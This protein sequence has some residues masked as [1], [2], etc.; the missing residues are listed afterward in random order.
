MAEFTYPSI[1]GPAFSLLDQQCIAFEKYDGSNLRFFWDRQRGWHSTGT[2]YRWFKEVTPVFGP[3]ALIFRNDFAGKIVESLR[4]FKEYRGVV[5]LIAF[6]EYF[7][8][9]TF[10]GLHDADEPKQLMCF[11]DMARRTVAAS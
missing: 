9:H 1:Q 6:C 8:P 7:G 3:A 11:T 10:S 2:R 5:E 4:R